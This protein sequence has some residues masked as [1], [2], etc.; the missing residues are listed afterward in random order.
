MSGRRIAALYAIWALPLLL[1]LSWVVPPWTNTDEPFHMLRAVQIAH[2]QIIGQRFENPDK[3]GPKGSGGLSDNAIFEAFAPL[4]KMSWLPDQ[5]NGQ[6]TRAMLAKSNTVK[7]HRDLGLAWFG[8]TVRYPPFFYMPDIAGYW[9]G[10]AAGM[11]VNAT[12]RLSRCL[13]ALVFVAMAAVSIARARRLRLLLATLLMLPMTL[14]LAASANQ[15]GTMIAGMALIVAQLDRIAAE[16]R[17][18]RPWEFTAL[19]CGMAVII[20]ARPP[21]I[22]LLPI[23]LAVAPG[24]RAKLSLLAAAGAIAAWCAAVAYYAMRPLNGDPAT[25]LLVLLAYPLSI[26]TI[27]AKTLHIYAATYAW[28]FVGLLAWNDTRLPLPYLALAYGTIVLAAAASMAGPGLRSRFVLP[29]TLLVAAIMFAVQ[30]L[31][32][33]PAGADHVDG[34]FG[35][36]FLPPA[37]AL[38]LA[39]P[40]WCYASRLTVPAYLAIAL[41]AVATPAIMVHHI[42]MHFYIGLHT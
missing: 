25:K 36:Y 8:A 2:G 9:I 35:R 16:N 26:F 20:A 31:D 6:V 32:W 30:Y 15:D 34:I 42:A 10:R 17:R 1:V 22:G 38:G 12:L 39:L 13:N 28:Q 37:L 27:F 3:T 29:C 21:Y 33:T 24:H 18:A 4:A 5:P 40:A 11:H 19:V 41:F 14:A 7:W 23:L